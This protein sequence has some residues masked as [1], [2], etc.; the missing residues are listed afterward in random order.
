MTDDGPRSDTKL[1]RIEDK[2]DRSLVGAV[3]FGRS[4]L[5]ITTM[6]EAM[7]FA[8]L[9]S[10]SGQ[11]VRA[12]FRGNPGMCL[13]V[14]IQAHE[15]GMNP[16]AVA[17]K[18]YIVSDQLAFESQ[19]IHAVIEARAPLKTR[20]NCTYDGEGQ[21][22]RCTVFATFHGDAEPRIYQ[23]PMFKDIRVKN[24]PLW[25]SD[26]DQQLFYYGSRS[27]VRKWCPD[28]LL[29]VYAPD[30]MLDLARD[31]KTF[32]QV[33]NPLKDDDEGPV[34]QLHEEGAAPANVTAQPGA[35]P[36]GDYDLDGS[37][38]PQLATPA[39]EKPAGETSAQ[40]APTK[41]P[42]Q[43]SP[44]ATAARAGRG[45]PTDPDK[46]QFKDP[47]RYAGPEY[48]AHLTAWT[49]LAPDA[50]YVAKRFKDETSLRNS[51]GTPL[52]AGEREQAA[53]IRN[54]AIDRF[55]GR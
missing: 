24:S 28:V 31:A 12:P 55:K 42:A 48:L 10:L 37:R 6:A 2:L 19:L 32:E 36:T 17:S 45:K 20:L 40:A 30:E 34:R 43:E 44:P 38:N 52:T 9:M 3:R 4:S 1:A 22:R 13:A 39:P 41:P 35:A 11:A 23:T 14:C 33:A 7:E 47:I 15:W 53:V 49:A 21:T 18:A 26:L 29:G 5:A 27:W 16:Y 46:V 51:L 8:K 50:D 54:A 25:Q